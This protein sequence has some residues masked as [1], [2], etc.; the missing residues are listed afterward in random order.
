LKKKEE[1]EKGERAN[2][3]VG[4]CNVHAMDGGPP[5]DPGVYSPPF[6]SF[7][8]HI[9][10]FFILLVGQQHQ[11]QHKKTFVLMAI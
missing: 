7:Y 1:E 4:L 9:C 10:S 6:F 2:E 3:E 11:Q 5:V 8:I